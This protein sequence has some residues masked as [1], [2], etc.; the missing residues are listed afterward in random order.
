MLFMNP[1]IKTLPE[2]KL[3][4][5]RINMSLTNNK[6]FELWKSFMPRRKEIKNNLGTELFSMKVYD[7]SYDFK[8]FDPSAEFEKWAA[9][10]VSDFD[11]IPDEMDNWTLKSGLYAVFHYKGLSTDPKIFEYIFG[12]WLLNSTYSLDNRPHFEILGEKYKNNDRDSEE[13]IW[14]P[15]KSK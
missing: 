7:E 1:I 15:I 10:E 11:E 14:I 12:T 9:I 5:K 2:K 13:E 6:T 8:N 4:G 3:I